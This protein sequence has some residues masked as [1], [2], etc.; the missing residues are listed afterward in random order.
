[1][2]GFLEA[3]RERGTMDT[4]KPSDS[5]AVCPKC[6]TVIPKGEKDCPICGVLEDLLDKSQKKD[7]GTGFEYKTKTTVFGWPIFHIAFGREESGKFRVAKGVVAI[8]QFARGLIAVGQVSIGILFGFGQLAT[9]IFSIGQV[10]PA[11]IF[12]IGQLTTGHIAI[13]QLAI[14]DWV[15]AQMGLGA[16]VWSSTSANP[17]AVAFFTGMWKSISGFISGLF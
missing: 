10:A 2:T 13:G 8:G 7:G 12:G 3:D 1:M 15:L 16:H 5:T 9:G 11:V 6:G 14:G 4:I 17:E